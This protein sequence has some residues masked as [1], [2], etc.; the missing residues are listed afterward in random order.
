MIFINPLVYQNLQ[1]SFLEFELLLLFDCLTPLFLSF[2][3]IVQ[4]LV[5]L[6]NFQVFETL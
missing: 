2:C 3:V 1:I 6:T 5:M 4:N